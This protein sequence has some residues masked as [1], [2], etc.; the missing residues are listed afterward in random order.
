M[1]SMPS[2]TEP[3]TA[4]SVSI[5]DGQRNLRVALSNGQVVR[6]SAEL[7]RLNCRCASCS[8]ARIDGTFGPELGGIAIAQ[9]SPMGAYGLN[10][11]FTDGHARGIFPFAYLAELAAFQA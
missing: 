3:F 7:L 11:A 9:A 8:R 10:I 1:Q 5:S 6:L 4:Q 2:A